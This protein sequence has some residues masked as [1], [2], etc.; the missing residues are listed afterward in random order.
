VAFT[1]FVPGYWMDRIHPPLDHQEA[2]QLQ[3]VAQDTPSGGHLR[4]TIEGMDLE[5]REISKAVMLPLGEPGPGSERLTRAGLGT[6][7]LGDQ[8]SVSFVA[9]GSDADRLGIESGW[10]ITGVLVPAERPAPEWFYLPA[11]VILGSIVWLQR[12][13]LK[14]R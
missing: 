8:V 4:F 2:S 7:T 10:Q 14:P 5:G 9:F 12:R 13:R 3:Q 6:M 11:L 1:L